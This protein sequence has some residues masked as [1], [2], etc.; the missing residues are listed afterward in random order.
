MKKLFSLLTLALLTMSAWAATT[1]TIDL[2]AQGYANQQEVTSVTDADGLVTLTFDKGTNSNTPKYFTSGAAVRLYGGGTL[3]VSVADGSDPITGIT[4]TFGSS[5][6]TNAITSNVGTFES[7]N[8]TGS[9]NAVTFTVGGTTGHRRFAKVEVTLSG[10]AGE[11]VAAPV[12]TPVTGSKF[13]DSQVITLT[14]ATEGATIYYTTDS[15]F[16]EYTAPF[17][18]TETSTIK[19]KAVK[20]EKE[21]SVVT[22]KYYRM[23]EVSTLAEANALPHNTDFIFN[24]NPIVIYRNGSYTFVKDETAF[25]LIYGNQVPAEVVTGC[26][27]SEEWDAV[28]T[29]YKDYVHEY[30]KPNNVSKS[31]VELIEITPTEYLESELTTDNINER[32]IIKGV[33]ITKNGNNYYTADG[34][35][36]YNQFGLEMPADLEGKTFDVEGMV[37]YYSALQLYPINIT[38][39]GG[40]PIVTCAA[41]TLPAATTF[42]DTYE[43]VITNNE[44][45]ATIYYALNDG[46][47]QVYNDPFT[48]TETTTVKAYATLNGVNSAE[49]SA[50]YTKVEP[51]VMRTFA[52]V[53]DATQLADGDKVIFVST[54]VAGDAYAMGAA[55]KNNFGHASVTITED[56]TITTDQANVVNLEAQEGN[57]AMKVNEGYL[58]AAGTTG[59]GN[60]Y[61]RAQA[62]IDD[63]SIASIAIDADSAAATIIFV[64]ATQRNYLRYNENAA[65]NNPLFSCYNED[66]SVQTPVYIFKEKAEDA[67][68][69]GDVDAD[70]EVNITDVVAL[71]DCLLNPN[72]TAPT[73]ADCDLDGIVNITDVAVLIDY[74]I[75]H[76]WNE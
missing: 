70:G 10:E 69:R 47:F 20:G 11:T 4:F 74:L 63:L 18:I 67:G 73:S 62:E 14:C 51:A 71:I 29:L 5:D 55:N 3:T 17:T 36:L 22:A 48:L 37:T 45:G 26:T 46:E 60:N 44:E 27:L 64:N 68:L 58:Y 49:V 7:P 21:S 61:L 43:V 34:M 57:W 42:T 39:A 16:Q 2:T 59:N 12:F 38:L 52:L 24:G 23:V 40:Q 1:V 13:I 30:T 15:V 28:Y 25:G 33:T 6:G 54:P 8:W 66:S 53:T 31:N 56:L 50:T 76:N 72:A 65:N 32:V 35:Q 9:A 19:A 41:P 75:S